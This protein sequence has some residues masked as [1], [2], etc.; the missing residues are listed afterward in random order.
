MS[1]TVKILIISTIVLSL[2]AFSPQSLFLFFS[3]ANFVA[4]TGEVPIST[5]CWK[6]CGSTP[7]AM[8]ISQDKKDTESIKSIMSALETSYEVDPIPSRF[9]PLLGLYRSEL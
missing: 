4:E 1:I 6:S 2:N 5:T 7:L 9:T 3:T 8:M